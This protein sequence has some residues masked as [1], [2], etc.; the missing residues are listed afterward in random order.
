M[1]T[2]CCAW[3]LQLLG[4]LL[5]LGGAGSCQ[6]PQATEIVLGLATD[7]TSAELDRVVLTRDG[8]PRPLGDWRLGGVLPEGGFFQLPA[9]YSLYTR[10]E[11]TPTIDITLTGF[12]GGQEVVQRRARVS[13]V[14]ERTLFLRMAL[15]RACREQ[16]ACASGLTCIEG[17][18]VPVAVDSQLLP[19]YRQGMERMVD[20]A[21]NTSLRDTKSGDLLPLYDNPQC[22]EAESCS[23]GIC[24]L[25]APNEV[26]VG[27]ATDLSVPDQL[28]RA[29]LVVRRAGQV[30]GSR[31]WRLVSD[32]READRLPAVFRLSTMDGSEPTV[33]VEVTGYRGS[34]E[35]VRRTAVL[36]LV[37][38]R[39]ELNA[40]PQ[41]NFVRLALVEDC[42]NQFGCP[43]GQTCIEGQCKVATVDPVRLLPYRP[44]RE[45]EVE[46]PS[47]T[48]LIDTSTGALLQAT[49][50]ESCNAK[51]CI[52]SLCYR[53]NQPLCEDGRQDGSETDV[54][55]GGPD[56]P[57]CDGKRACRGDADCDS[58]VCGVG[59]CAYRRFGFAGKVGPPADDSVS[60]EATYAT[61]KAPYS[62]AIGDL[63][64][65][66]LLDL[67]VANFLETYV[68]V[69]LNQGGVSFAPAASYNVGENPHSVAIEDLD[70]DGWRDLA[71]ANSGGKGSVSVLLNQG[72]GLSFARED[73]EVSNSPFSVTVG[74]LDG[75]EGPDLAVAVS[76]TCCDEG[77]VS[78]L[79]N[80]GREPGL[81]FALRSSHPVS[82]SPLSVAVGELDGKA[83]L[84]LAVANFLG[85]SVSVLLNGGDARFDRKDSRAGVS[86]FSVAVG[87]LDGK[88]GLDLAVATVGGGVGLLFNDGRGGFGLDAAYPTGSF[89]SSVAV[90][91]LN[92]DGQLDLAVTN[93]GAVSNNVSVLL[94][95]P[96]NLLGPGRFDLDQSYPAGAGPRS[97]AMGDLDGDG[98]L[99]LAV[100]NSGSS[101]VSV[102]Y[103]RGRA[104]YDSMIELE[105]G[106]AP[107]AMVAGDLDGDGQLD[108][109]VADDA[110]QKVCILKGRE[111]RLDRETGC[112]VDGRSSALALGD[113]NHDG[114]PDLVVA[115]QDAG[116]V[117]V[118]LNEGDQ[119]G[120]VFGPSASSYE[121]GMGLSAMVLE[122][123]D[124]DH[125]M[126]L[127]VL[128]EQSGELVIRFNAGDGTFNSSIR[129]STGVRPSAIVAGDWSGDGQ[130]DLAV[131]VAQDNAVIL[132]K[133]DGER[134]FFIDAG[135]V[136]VG[137]SP[138]AVVAADLNDDRLI[139]L[140][141]ANEAS[142][143][144][145]VLLNQGEDS[146]IESRLS[147]GP[148]APR[149]VAVRDL[150]G[151]GRPDI[152]TANAANN[153]VSVLL[154][155]GTIGS[156]FR[157][158]TAR[159]FRVGRMMPVALVLEDIDRDSRPDIITANA[160]STNEPGNV[161]VL[162]NLSR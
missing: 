75:G 123:F 15:V 17:Q 63:N 86:P 73:Y 53:N 6:R 10:D 60:S 132:L 143:D 99:D 58:G 144:V 88:P 14:R 13:F 82:A 98:R 36:Q 46:C 33:E 137:T 1:N 158:Q 77:Y 79:L 138:K 101:N 83:G 97:V 43:G 55:C 41:T 25:R 156:V 103:N 128:N 161:T 48:Q 30:V 140:V 18:C 150:N 139:D 66:G 47:G 94:N 93:G 141:V 3:S 157:A 109:V 32:T 35:R 38:S 85:N 87:N 145:S 45:K 62:V 68:S 114:L 129:Y 78:V 155:K 104:R 50:R 134:R 120:Q 52:E 19:E 162:F 130:A 95:N 117:S 110:S 70:G 90:G 92:G 133:S 44:Q 65:D 24:Y 34:A 26:M 57:R 84:D 8:F 61:G 160:G 74:E 91:D 5:V 113:L 107:R 54:D 11:R 4:G 159:I 102:L 37:N 23:E 112:E 126:D 56:C 76:T 72:Q 29:S 115:N 108:L 69:L 49:G 71:V 124:G 147:I 136:D 2:R 100:A 149:S 105:A 89:P 20:C 121:V 21:S 154:S 142:S 51:E 118:Y 9:S 135:E 22:N 40:L 80:R 27:V 64:R 42:L 31:Q 153:A 28:D 122:D 127:A 81:Q 119:R 96:N 111:F 59:T 12:S 16:P 148:D 106:Q 39:P 7:L 152:V 146:F 151:D 67:A 116:T 125:W 131:A